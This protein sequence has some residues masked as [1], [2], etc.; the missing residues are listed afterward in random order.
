VFNSRGQ[1]VQFDAAYARQG[2]NSTVGPCFSFPA[3]SFSL[4]FENNSKGQS[5]HV[6]ILGFLAY[7]KQSDPIGF[8]L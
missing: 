1:S 8:L 7:K 5:S 4:S 6:A 2:P 3:K